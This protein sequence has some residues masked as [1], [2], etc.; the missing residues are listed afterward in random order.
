MRSSCVRGRSRA[1][2]VGAGEAGSA[3]GQEDL[4][5]TPVEAGSMESW[6]VLGLRIRGG[7]AGVEGWTASEDDVPLHLKSRPRDN[8]P[9]IGWESCSNASLWRRFPSDMGQSTELERT[10]GEES[11][12]MTTSDVVASDVVASVITTTSLE[13]RDG[14]TRLIVFNRRRN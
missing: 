8:R 3:G 1:I 5:G 4:S 12:G 6:V 9:A 13:G 7:V 14:T 10:E 11:G 2:S